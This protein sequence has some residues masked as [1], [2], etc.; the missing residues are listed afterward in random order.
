M[1]WLA[2]LKA[3]AL[4]IAAGAGATG[5]LF[6]GKKYIPGLLA[7]LI[8]K[9]LGQLLNLKSDDPKEAE[10]VRGVVLAI[11]K[12]VE[13]KIPDKGQGKARYDAAA[14]TLTRLIPALAGQEAKISALIEDAVQRMDD[15]FKKAAGGQ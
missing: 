9:H 4:L 11:V 1:E 3:K 10:L 8:Q 13:Y 15:E 5:L 2:L 14:A 12:L 6:L 7:G